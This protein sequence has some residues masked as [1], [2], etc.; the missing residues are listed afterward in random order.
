MITG[1]GGFIG[2][3]LMKHCLEAGCSVLGLGVSEPADAW[4]GCVFERCDIRDAK[5]LSHLV[6][7]FRPDRIFH[8][9]AQS[10]PTV[11]LEQP[12]ETI[13]INVGGTVNLFECVR[14]AEILP[15]VVVA[16]SSAEYGPVAASDLPVRENHALRPLHPYG[17]SKVGQDLLAAQYFA[18]YSIPSVR[19]RIFNT[20]GPG[21]IG[22]VCSDLAKRVAEMELGMRPPALTV[23]NLTKRA[24][25]DVRDLVRGLWL[26]AEYCVPGDVYNLGGNDIYSVQ[27]VIDTIR[28]Y[29]KID[30]SVEQDPALVRGCDE[31]V[32][33]GDVSKFRRCSGWKTEIPLAKTVQDM[34]EWWRSR[35]PPAS[36]ADQLTLDSR[37]SELPV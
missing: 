31:P 19:I 23:G 35:L 7:T 20:T 16:C 22:D 27:E 8:M 9:A 13:D 37:L 21:K 10:Y 30:F 12:L 2:G 29:A 1:A 28:V 26:S 17:V 6:S 24:I 14:A 34:L 5:R 18:N 33:A 32:I 36:I 15:I 25:A 11:S 3:F 4:T